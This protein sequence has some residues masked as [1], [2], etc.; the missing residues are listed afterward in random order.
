MCGWVGGYIGF[1]REGGCVVFWWAVGANAGWEWMGIGWLGG[2]IL[3]GWIYFLY[4]LILYVH[5]Q[6]FS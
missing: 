6:S 4:D 5:Q 2:C 3:G 1:D